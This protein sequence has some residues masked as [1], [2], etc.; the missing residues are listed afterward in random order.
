MN[1]YRIN[2]SH[3]CLYNEIN[4]E[5]NPDEPC[6]DNKFVEFIVN[7]PSNNEIYIAKIGEEIIGCAT[8]I[9]EQKMIHNCAKVGHIEDVFIREQYRKKGYGTI[10]V[11]YL[12]S[13]AKEN[14]CYK[15]ILD[16]NEDF[17]GFYWNCGFESKNIQM[18]VY[19]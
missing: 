15:V 8:L 13:V 5:F 10:L 11:N 3:Q 7:I 1:F 6:N 18:S 14:G 16:C 4:R 19:F 2:L 9:I 17:K 12:K